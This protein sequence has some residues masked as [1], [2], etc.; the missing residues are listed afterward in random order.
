MTPASASSHAPHAAALLFARFVGGALPATRLCGVT[1]L[2]D[3]T[4]ASADERLAFSRFFL[5]A[6]AED[7]VRLPDAAE[8]ADLLAIARA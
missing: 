5:E 8:M 4:N 1:D 3:D 2:L 7:D 6:S